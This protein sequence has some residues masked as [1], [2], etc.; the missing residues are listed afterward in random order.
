ME[1]KVIEEER[2]DI[3][4]ILSER[5]EAHDE[6][7]KAA[8]EKLHNFCEGLRAQIDKLEN[9]INSE[10]EEKF[11]KEDNRLQTALNELRASEEEGLS[12]VIQRAKTELL[13]IQS[14]DVIERNTKGYERKGGRGDYRYENNFNY[15]DYEDDH[16]DIDDDD[17]FAILTGKKKKTNT[18][19]KFKIS[20]LYTS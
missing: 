13:V 15:L 8:Q 17:Y 19:E 12:K 3:S 18:R 1:A 10:I 20:R 4:K 14:Y 6:S 16:D 2:E 11:T 7:R 5:L 9:R